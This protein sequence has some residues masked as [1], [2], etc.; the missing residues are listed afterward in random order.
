MDVSD[1]PP[2]SGTTGSDDTSKKGG[3]D[4]DWRERSESPTQSELTSEIVPHPFATMLPV[5]GD[6]AK[7]TCLVWYVSFSSLLTRFCF[8]E[9][10]FSITCSFCI[11]YLFISDSAQL[12]V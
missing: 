10:Y 6:K 3:S 11:L 5:C 8:V 9:P 12:Q 1:N 4:G 2:P 7:I